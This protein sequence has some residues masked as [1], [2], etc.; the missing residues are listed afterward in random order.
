MEMLGRKGYRLFQ[1]LHV[2]VAIMVGKVLALLRFQHRV[3][4]ESRLLPPH[5]AE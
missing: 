2:A 5:A 1:K 3:G 4:Q